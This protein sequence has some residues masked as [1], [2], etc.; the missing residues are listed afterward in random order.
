[1]SISISVD[2]LSQGANYNILLKSIFF[3]HLI[4]IFI[5]NRK[6]HALCLLV[7]F[8][9]RISVTL[10]FNTFLGPIPKNLFDEATSTVSLVL[11][12]GS[13]SFERITSLIGSCLLEIKILELIV[14]PK[15]CIESI[16]LLHRLACVDIIKK[17]LFTFS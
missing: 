4:L 5:L 10:R 1:M 3:I 16:K 14:V 9:I 8:L 11:L 2:L 6:L 13:L 7:L 15:D 12:I 17:N